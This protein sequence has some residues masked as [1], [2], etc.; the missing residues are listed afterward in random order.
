M[1]G[2]Q[3]MLTAQ[4]I[5]LGYNGTPLC[6][7]L[8]F[9]LAAGQ[10]CAVIG[11]N[12][13]GKSTLVRTLLGIQTPLSGTMIWA[14]NSNKNIAYLGQ[15]ANIDTHFPMRVK[16]AVTMGLWSQLGFWQGISKSMT[17]RVE[18]A[19]M[20]TGLIHMAER[21]L[22]E[23][24]A[25]Q[26][27]RCFFARAIVQDSPIIILDEPFTAIDQ[28]TESQLLEIMT[29]WRAEGRTL[30]IVLHDLS[31]VM[32]LTDHCLLLGNG[33]GLFGKTNDVVTHENLVAYHYLTATQAE[34]I[35][36]L[37]AAGGQDV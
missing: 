17:E 29:Q 37:T 24:S 7:P 27:Q 31:S 20:R 26:L 35:A 8:D 36:R 12:G 25:G 11:H 34:W 6:E 23:C 15:S 14:K 32:G 30:I 16:D 1:G 9:T 10:V 13:A 4:N 22:F 21:P 5:V 3:F 2:N 28:T 33:R 19:L 18:I